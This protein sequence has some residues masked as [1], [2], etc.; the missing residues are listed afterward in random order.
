MQKIGKT[1]SIETHLD[2]LY[3]LLR[4]YE[5]D[6][7]W[8]SEDL[9][10]TPS[11]SIFFSYW[12]FIKAEFLIEEGKPLEA[13]KHLVE[14]M[15]EEKFYPHLHQSILDTI[16]KLLHKY[17]IDSSPLIK[18]TFQRNYQKRENREYLFIIDN[19]QPQITHNEL[20]QW[21]KQTR[22]AT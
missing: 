3:A 2:S 18:M 15:S 16:E 5:K 14:A 10:Y 1:E 20:K 7:G 6:Y 12:W 9:D 11:P 13:F 4:V 17:Q 19:C 21:K 22:S 8:H